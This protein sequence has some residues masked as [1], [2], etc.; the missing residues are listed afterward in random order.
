MKLINDFFRITDTNIQDETVS[1][2]VALNPEH[3][4]YGAHFPGNPVTPGVCLLQMATEILEHHYS[5]RLK[6]D[7]AVNIRFKNP[8]LPAD[9]TVFDF[10]KISF[11]ADEAKVRL[12]VKNDTKQF[13]TMSLK[14]KVIE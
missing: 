4:I 9:E 5:K 3:Y 2:K 12:T 10:T 6:L 7:T 14:Y 11:E 13:V 8:V 1:Y